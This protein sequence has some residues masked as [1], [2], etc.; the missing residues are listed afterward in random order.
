VGQREKFQ[1][2]LEVVEHETSRCSQIV[3]GLLAFSRK[4][5]PAF[6]KVSVA[7]LINRCTTLSQHRLELQN[8]AL[9]V[10]VEPDLPAVEGDFNQLQQCVINL[11]FNAVDSMPGGGTLSVSGRYDASTTSVTLT[12]KDTGSGISEADLPYIFEPFFSTK[13]EGY[14]VGLG[15]STVYGILERHRGHIKVES[16]LGEGSTFTIS[17]PILSHP[18]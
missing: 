11:I 8:I 4:S 7:E 12:I 18:A 16:R 9:E 14:G 6:E 10:H 3:S 13:Q 1:Q 17:L 15:L 2:Y 5:P